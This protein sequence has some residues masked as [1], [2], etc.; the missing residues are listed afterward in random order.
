MEESVFYETAMKILLVTDSRKYKLWEKSFSREAFNCETDVYYTDYENKLIRMFHALPLAG[1]I[2][3]HISYWSISAYWALYIKTFSCRKYTHIIFINPIV[4]FFYGL[5]SRKVGNGSEFYLSGFLF[6]SKSRKFYYNL[7]KWFVNCSLK[8][9]SAVYVYSHDE[10]D[11]YSA[12]FPDL[13]C[14]FKFIKYGRDFHIFVE[15]E[16]EPARKY[17]A[18]GG[19]SNRDYKTLTGA[20]KLLEDIHP[21]LF[22]YVAARPGSYLIEYNPKNLKFLFNIRIDKFGSFIQQSEFVVLPLL[23]T[24]LSAGHMTLLESMALGRN[25]I[26]ADIPSVRDY[27]DDELVLFYKPGDARDLAKKIES[28]YLGNN[29]T[30]QQNRSEKAREAY[31][32]SYTFTSFLKRI[33]ADIE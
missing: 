24:S 25:I 4:G 30:E 19:I 13:A 2:L 23:N 7:R 21:G 15:N 32:L 29:N 1:N 16:F 20:M 26:I 11:V 3:S 10:V 12:I 18:S 28:L 6:A 17:F 33:A 14:K 8:N 9:A 27:V 22:C 31:S 5:L